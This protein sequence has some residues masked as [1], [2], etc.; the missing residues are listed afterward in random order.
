MPWEPALEAI[1]L[2]LKFQP[3]MEALGSIWKQSQGIPANLQGAGSRSNSGWPILLTQ[4]KRAVFDSSLLI[5][6][7]ALWSNRLLIELRSRFNLAIPVNQVTL[8]A[9]VMLILKT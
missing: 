5:L 9:T 4:P 8:M 1:L 3:T 6:V 7:M 2:Q